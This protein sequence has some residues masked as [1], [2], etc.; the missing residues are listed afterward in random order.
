MPADIYNQEDFYLSFS[1]VDW[2]QE[3]TVIEIGSD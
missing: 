1:F 2:I 3:L